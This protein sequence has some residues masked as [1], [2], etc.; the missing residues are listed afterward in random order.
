MDVRDRF[1]DPQGH[2]GVETVLFNSTGFQIGKVDSG[3][4]EEKFTEIRE[5]IDRG[6]IALNYCPENVILKECL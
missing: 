4:F 1:P 6:E 5:T 2:R 3:N